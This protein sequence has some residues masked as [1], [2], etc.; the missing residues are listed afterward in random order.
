MPPAKYALYGALALAALGIVPGVA[1]A[2]SDVANASGGLSARAA[3]DFGI[4]VPHV[5]QMRLLGH[6]AAL[7]LSAEDIARGDIRVSGASLDLL[8]N[9]RLGYFVRAEL[10]AGAFSAVKIVGLPSPVVATPAGTLI[11]MDSM[12]GKPKPAPMPLEYELQIAPDAQPGTYA[13]PVRLS[14]QQL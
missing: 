9:D 13:W 11:R 7:Q 4:Q 14:L 2:A 6:P 10:A 1:G 8:V 5:M 12:V 3:V